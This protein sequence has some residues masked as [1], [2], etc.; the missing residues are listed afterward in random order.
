MPFAIRY[1]HS[2]HIG[3]TLRESTSRLYPI[4]LVGEQIDQNIS[5]QREMVQECVKRQGAQDGESERASERG[6]EGRRIREM[7]KQGWCK[8][9]REKRRGRS[10]E[11]SSGGGLGRGQSGGQWMGSTARSSPGGV[12]MFGWCVLEVGTFEVQ[13]AVAICAELWWALMA[14][15]ADVRRTWVLF[16]AR[17]NQ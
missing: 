3:I 8:R 4:L 7:L 15:R 9:M 6:R 10:M 2:N 1:Y 12:V 14:L 16:Y 5:L 13:P 11:E 17:S